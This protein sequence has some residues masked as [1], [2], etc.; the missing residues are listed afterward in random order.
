MSRGC[1]EECVR[2]DPRDR[3]F[4][5]SPKNNPLV[6]YHPRIDRF[7]GP[8][9]RIELPLARSGVVP[10]SLTIGRP[11]PPMIR[12]G[13][14]DPGKLLTARSTFAVSH[15][16]QIRFKVVRSLHLSAPIG[17][18]ERRRPRGLFSTFPLSS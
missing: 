1:L 15:A 17:M 16:D 18:R 12:A 10:I 6:V 7:A 8:R 5:K 14:H 13:L 3:F 2:R 9:T 11:A 4:G